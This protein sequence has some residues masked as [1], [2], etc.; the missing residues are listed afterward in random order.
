MRAVPLFSLGVQLTRAR[1]IVNE[2]WI[3]RGGE[4][5]QEMD[6]EEDDDDHLEKA[7]DFEREYNFRFEEEYVDPIPSSVWCAVRGNVKA[8]RCAL[9]WANDV[10]EVSGARST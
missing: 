4:E 5:E 10:N 3:N 7:D 6:V 9:T 1:Y 2:G 8:M